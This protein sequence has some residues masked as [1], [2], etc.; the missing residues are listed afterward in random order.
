MSKRKADSTVNQTGRRGSGI[1]LLKWM[2]RRFAGMKAACYADEALTALDA[3]DIDSAL[4]GLG[5]RYGRGAGNSE[6]SVGVRNAQPLETKRW[7]ATMHRFP[8]P[9][10][11]VL[12]SRW[13]RT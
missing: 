2:K 10:R 7:P 9:V 4:F 13:G 12:R 11:S 8:R 6:H 3:G 5:Q 1:S